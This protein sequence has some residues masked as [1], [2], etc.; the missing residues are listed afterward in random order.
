MW[1]IDP[2]RGGPMASTH[3]KPPPP[4]SS[5]I[6]KHTGGVGTRAVGETPVSSC[7]FPS[8]AL[9][10]RGNDVIWCPDRHVSCFLGN[11]GEFVGVSEERKMGSMT[12]DHT[13]GLLPSSCV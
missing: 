8:T 10:S 2:P 6:F 7:R 4:L 9:F 3:R 11:R 13:A 1:Y 5:A 12:H